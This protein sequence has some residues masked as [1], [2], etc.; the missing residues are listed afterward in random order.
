VAMLLHLDK[1]KT[2]RRVWNWIIRGWVT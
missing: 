1:E 2:C